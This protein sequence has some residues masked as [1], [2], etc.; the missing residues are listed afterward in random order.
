MSGRVTSANVSL[1]VEIT[2]YKYIYLFVLSCFFLETP[3]DTVVE[4]CVK[5]QL[6]PINN[7]MRFDAPSHSL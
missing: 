2:K 4:L 5:S 7:V 6:P 3:C 1:L